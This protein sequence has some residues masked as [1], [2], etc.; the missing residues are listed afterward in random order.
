MRTL[1][2]TP[3]PAGGLAGR[4]QNEHVIGDAVGWVAA[5]LYGRTDAEAE[6]VLAVL[7]PEAGSSKLDAIKADLRRANEDLRKL[8][9]SVGPSTDALSRLADRLS[10]LDCS[11]PGMNNM[12]YTDADRER[13]AIVAEIRKMAQ[14]K[15]DGDPCSSCPPGVTCR[16]PNCGRL[17]GLPIPAREVRNG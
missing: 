15:N 10:R 9:F 16:T 6:A 7:Q 8:G 3:Y 17:A 14:G 5:R 11:V 2:I 13:D 12:V 4:M 1:R